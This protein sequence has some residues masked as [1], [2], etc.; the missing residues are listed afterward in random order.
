MT[1]TR[2]PNAPA[3]EDFTDPAAAVARLEELYEQATGFLCDSFA[4]AIANGSPSERFRAYYPEI[5]IRTSSYAQVDSR[6]SFGHVAEPGAHATTVTRPDL[7]RSYLTQQI[8]LL[9]RNHDQPVTIG[10]STTPIPVHFAVANNPD[11]VVPH[12]A[13]PVLPCA[14]CST[15]R[16]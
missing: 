6:L 4:D 11:L 13:P 12:Q 8:A 3:P 15:C 1:E 14:T 2:T 16:T 7:F 5:R 9:I 10:P